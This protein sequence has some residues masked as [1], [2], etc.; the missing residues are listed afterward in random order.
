MAAD[1]AARLVV[2]APKGAE[3]SEKRPVTV[4]IG[5]GFGS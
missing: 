4:M 5:P 3:I 2:S 1:M